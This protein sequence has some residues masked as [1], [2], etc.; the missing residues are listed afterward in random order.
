M[1]RQFITLNNSN[2]TGGNNYTL[3]F[4]KTVSLDKDTTLSLFSFTMY[5]SFYNISQRQFNNANIS[6][7]WFDN[8]IY[9]WVIPDGYYSVSDLNIWL[10]SQFIM[11][12]LYCT[13]SSNS[14]N[15]FF[16]AFKINAVLYKNQIDTNYVPSATNAASF[17]YIKPI[18]ATWNFPSV[19]TCIN[20]SINT[21]LQKYF[22]INNQLDFGVISPVQNVQYVSNVCPTVSNTFSIFLT[23]NL[24][25][26]DFSQVANVFAQIPIKEGFGKLIDYNAS[27]NADINV[28][29]GV[30]NSINIGLW[31]QN[32][33][34]LQ[35]QDDELVIMLVI[36]HK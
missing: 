9:N 30:Y 34:P 11:N 3:R 25:V 10:Q 22:G 28:Q 6:F 13:N 20:I 27:M 36:D 32:N 5:N 15:I 29:P 7:T 21:G 17:G 14:L 12:N 18:G 33:Y 8:T 2:Y 23:C 1:V 26:S 16:V 19:N 4:P 35:F 24:I 31:D